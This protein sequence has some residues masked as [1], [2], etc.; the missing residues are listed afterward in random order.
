MLKKLQQLQKQSRLWLWYGRL[1]PLFFLIGTTALYY[2]YNTTIPLYFYAAWATF[3]ITGFIW[4]AWVIKVIVD[5][6]H[7]FHDIHGYIGHIQESIKEVKED[8]KFLDGSRKD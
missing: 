5:L 7:L 8:V 2:I 1:T 4:W 3:I 6:I